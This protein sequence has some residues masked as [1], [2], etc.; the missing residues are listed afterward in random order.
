M[1]L[2]R[3]PQTSDVQWSLKV[4]PHVQHSAARWKRSLH[5]LLPGEST[6]ARADALTNAAVVLESVLTLLLFLEWLHRLHPLRVLQLL[7]QSI[8]LLLSTQVLLWGSAAG[9]GIAISAM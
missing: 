7:P 2:A 6:L 8:R 4:A 1:Q 9:S 5:L 3:I